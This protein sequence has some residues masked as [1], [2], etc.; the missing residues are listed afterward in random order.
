MWYIFIL[1]NSEIYIYISIYIAFKTEKNLAINKI[2]W[3]LLFDKMQGIK[4]IKK[5]IGTQK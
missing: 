5:G 2:A 3:E 1:E 4:V